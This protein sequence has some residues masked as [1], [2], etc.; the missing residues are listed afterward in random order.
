ME[1][2]ASVRHYFYLSKKN[3]EF[4]IDNLQNPYLGSYYTNNSI[5]KI[6]DKKKLNQTYNV[7]YFENKIDLYKI[8]AKQI[9]ENRVI[10]F[11]N[12]KMEFEQEH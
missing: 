12:G 1:V 8:I 4:D 3:N 10:G 9:K 7:K 11:F 6:I 5:R 2:G